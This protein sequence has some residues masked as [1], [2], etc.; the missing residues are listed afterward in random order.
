MAGWLQTGNPHRLAF[1]HT[2]PEH[3]TASRQ[4]HPQS[5]CSQAEQAIV[6][7]ILGDN[8]NRC[9]RCTIGQ[10]TYLGGRHCDGDLSARVLHLLPPIQLGDILDAKRME[11]GSQLQGHIP[12]QGLAKA[13]VELLHGGC[14]QVIVVVVAGQGTHNSQQASGGDRQRQPAAK[15]RSYLMRMK[16][17]LGTTVSKCLGV[18]GSASQPPRI[19]LT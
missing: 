4:S 14:V 12:G 2:D 19:G 6:A 9:K 1:G 16:S 18:N 7:Q 13:L 11:P 15:D 8:N 17:I 10:G 3:D 5:N